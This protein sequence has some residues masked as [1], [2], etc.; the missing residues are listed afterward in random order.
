MSG[1]G[2][3]APHGCLLVVGRPSRIS[4]N[5]REALPDVREWSNSLPDVQLLLVSTAGCPGVVWRPFRMLVVGRP[6]QMSGSG[7]ETLP[8]VPEWW[9]SLLDVRQLSIGPRISCR[10]S[11]LSGSHRE[12]IQDVRE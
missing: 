11:Q 10:P 6:S 5:G 3:E 4:V 8:D 9:E 12:T 2:R 1:S 7:R